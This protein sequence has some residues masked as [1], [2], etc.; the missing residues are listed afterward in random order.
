[1]NPFELLK[2][3]HRKVA[4][5]MEQLENIQ[6]G[7]DRKGQKD[8]FRQ[9][10]E[11]LEVHS[12][13][14]EAIFYPALQVETE[15]EEITREAYEEHKLVKTILNELEKMPVEDPQWMARFTVLRENVEHHVEEEEEEMFSKAHE[16][17]NELELSEIAQE[18]EQEKKRMFATMHE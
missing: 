12:Q 2:E 10:K 15:T 14:E 17:L 11:E 3:D 7:G 6:G 13:I 1:M 5:L 9:I 4:Q 16:V 18:M 8:L